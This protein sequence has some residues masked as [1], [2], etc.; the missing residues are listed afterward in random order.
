MKSA[1]E[2]YETWNCPNYPKTNSNEYCELSLLFPRLTKSNYLRI[3]I[4]WV[5]VGHL[6]LIE[7]FDS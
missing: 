6:Y 2:S 5:K 7:M 3:T 1:K 4:S